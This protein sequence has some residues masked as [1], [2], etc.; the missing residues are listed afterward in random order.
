MKAVVLAAGKGSR[1]FPVTKVVPKPLLP[2]ANR[3]TLA[4]AFDRLRECGIEDV[5]IV[6]GENEGALRAALAN[7]AEFGVRLAY[8]RQTEPLG[9][10]HALGYAREFA[11]DDDFVLY[12]GDAVYEKPIAP[13]V[14]A[15]R[16]AGCANLNLVL[17]VEDP[18]RFGV[19]TLDGDR[20]VR[21]VEKPAEP[22]SNWAMA[23]MYVF[24]PAI[25]PVLPGLAP[26]ARGEYEITD[27]I[28]ALIEQGEDVRAGKYDGLWFD[29]GTLES[30]LATSRFLTGGSTLV[31]DGAVVQAELGPHVVVGEGAQVAAPWVED[32]VVLPGARVQA[33]GPVR[34]SILGGD[35]ESRE[36]FDGALV[37]G[38]AG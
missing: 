15:F 26:S 38:G 30:F 16:A 9:L 2:L 7:G 25:W 31:G 22:E 1:L 20:I 24:S 14:E 21:L 29:T 32:T 37:H 19:A 17:E 13:Q 8:V 34:G 36:G 4:Y 12:L 5:C 33:G 35:V 27:A 10:A 28:Q 18:R 11:G 6:A 23:G 3:P